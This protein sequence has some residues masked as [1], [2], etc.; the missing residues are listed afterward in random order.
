MAKACDGENLFRESDFIILDEPTSALDPLSE[1][2]LIR[3][4]F[5]H[6]QD[7]GVLFITHRMGAARLADRIIV[8]KD[9]AFVE[10]GNHEELMALDGE[11]KRLYEAQSQLFQSKE[12][13]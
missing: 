13:A 9:G 7:Q 11:Y 10:E 8:M 4:L 2:S 3:K 1:I 6:T 12:M 5:D